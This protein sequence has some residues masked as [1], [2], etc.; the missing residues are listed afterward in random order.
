M[1]A[2]N[3]HS[4][5]G[6]QLKVFMTPDFALIPYLVNAPSPAIRLA[7]D[8]ITNLDSPEGFPERIAVGKE[9]TTV[10]YEGIWDGDNA[11]HQFLQAASTSQAICT[12]Q[13]VLTDTGAT[14]V[15]FQGYVS[16]EIRPET[17]RAVRWTLT[18]EVTGDIDITP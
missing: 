18:V 1:P 12:F 10:A 6:T 13:E 16:V 15:A 2:T 11:V 4:S 9:F 14:L 17:R 5:Q 3:A 7:F 8:D